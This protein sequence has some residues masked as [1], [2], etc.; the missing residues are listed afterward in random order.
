METLSYPFFI[1]DHIRRRVEK[2]IE[3]LLKG[4][5]QNIGLI[6]SKGLGKT[7]LLASLF[8]SFSS[9]P[10]L[11]PAYV[12]AQTLDYDHL[13]ER[14]VGALL[15][16]YFLGQSVKPPADFQLLLAAAAP[17][18]PKTVHK[19]HQLKKL[20]RQDKFA[21]SVRELFSLS[22][23]LA[24]EAQKKVLLMIDEFQALSEVPA[25]DPFTLLGR[26]IMVEKDTLYVVS[27]STTG[28]ARGIFRD[29]LSLLFGNFEIL[30]LA[31]FGFGETAD[32][33]TERLPGCL[34]SSAQTKFMIAM[35]NGEP[36]HLNFL[37][38]R[39]QSLLPAGFSGGIPTPLLI[40][41]FHAELFDERGRIDQMFERRLEYCRR[42]AKDPSPYLRALLAASDGR[43]K[44][45]GLATYIQ[46][47]ILET[48]KILQ[49][50]V[51]EEILTKRGSFYTLEDRLFRFWLKEVFQRR[52]HLF[53]PQQT[54]VEQ[55]LEEALFREYEK[56]EAE[57]QL[58]VTAR[59]E[60]LF[61]EFRNDVVEIRERKIR[62]PQFS[63]IAFR[64]TNGRVFPLF[65][66]NAKVR[67]FCQIVRE[68]VR[69]EDVATFLED[70][71]RFRKNVQR[72]VLIVLGGI[73]QNAKLMAQAA[74]IQ[75]WNLG[76]FNCLLD[77]YNQPKIILIPE[78]EKHGS[79]LGAVAQSV[80][81]A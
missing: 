41:A 33:L 6:G 4:Y 72:K 31:P 24:E 46:R 21:A 56:C 51:Q 39:L 70:L 65:A 5:R 30:D 27:S 34:F 68:T 49:R 12:D 3:D 25:A 44:I 60:S 47:R 57:G 7:H 1:R 17:L 23:T 53:T 8:D 81:T 63:E 26:E 61:K 54:P 77:L 19:I 36:L 15:S 48:K 38:D 59:V 62:C 18:L 10:N 9:L 2:R 28:K 32:F 52:N 74:K 29:K 35:T 76:D 14:W 16:G 11:I 45:L 73:D 67:W 42:L 69:E 64:P 20:M 40:K 79:D 22:G 58:D 55:G 13:V 71:K 50:L 43:R 80:H 75:L 66:R 37:M 78:K